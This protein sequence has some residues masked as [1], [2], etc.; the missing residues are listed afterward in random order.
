MAAHAETGKAF[1]QQLYGETATDVQGL[2]DRI[3]PD[4]GWF[5]N[6]IGYGLVYSFPQ[7]T[8]GTLM[9]PL[10]TS[11]TLVS[12][13]I[14][15]DTP[16]QVNWHLAGARRVGATM[17]EVK[18]AREIAMQCAELVGVKWKEGVP[19]VVDVLEQNAE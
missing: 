9:T 18:A 11:Y 5:S 6:T 12:A 4:L 17:E 14:A 2:L 16:R 15:N 19:E 13:L 3:Y 10:E 8:T 1:F 7:P